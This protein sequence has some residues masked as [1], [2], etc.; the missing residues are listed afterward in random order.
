M[1][2]LV[3]VAAL[4]FQCAL[5]GAQAFPDRPVRILIGFPVSTSV[6]IVGRLAAQKLSEMWGQPVVIDNRPGAGGNLAA[7]I[8]AKARPDGYTLLIA[9]NGLAISATLY[10]KLTYSAAKDLT[11]VSEYTYLPHVIVVTN[12]LPANSIKELIALAKAKP[13]QLNYGSG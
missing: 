9:N 11:G 5:A 4:L 8:V 13:G 6:D 12:S 3:F 10:G 1:L 2:R 7:D